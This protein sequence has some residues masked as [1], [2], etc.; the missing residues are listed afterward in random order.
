MN[1]ILIMFHIESSAGYAMDSLLLTFV[2]MAEA[3]VGD[4]AKIH[5]SFIRLDESSHCKLL[6][7]F[8]QLVEYDPA[9]KDLSQHAFIENYVRQYKIDVVFGFDQMLRQPAY[10]FLRRGGVKKIISYQG[11][12][13][14][15]LNKGIKL[16]IKKLEVLLT[17][18][19]PDHYIF[20]SKAMAKTA[21][22]GRG[23]S[24]DKVSIVYLG[25][26]EHRFKPS[27][28]ADNYAHDI[29]D[30][31]PERK[32][33]YY[34]GHMEERK[35]VAVLVR[36]ARYLYEHHKRRDF[37]LLILGNKEG[38]D[39]QFLQ[40][41]GNSG[42]RGH[43]TFGGYRNDV[44]KI[45]PCCYMGAIATTGWD[46]FTLSSLEVAACG[47]PLVVSRLQG[48]VET[49]EDGVTGFA[50]EPGDH[51]AFSAH[52]IT[53]L[54]NPDTRDRMGGNARKRVLLGFTRQQQVDNLVDVMKHVAT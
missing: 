36:A 40:L 17:P 11:A 1:A 13:M 44:E 54:D 9:S 26:D 53:L 19:S 6:S 27:E 25:V 15:G 38:E 30:I 35:G 4:R 7:E 34:S 23:V 8:D 52:V 33:L 45:I 39:Q 10:R 16:V 18:W 21:Y 24:R 3:L 41:L 14:S 22:Q 43:V 49:I 29:F 42:A 48:L 46:S 31:A 28:K 12:S 50:F 2:R 47:L 32:I 37:H 5:I 20:E 51:V